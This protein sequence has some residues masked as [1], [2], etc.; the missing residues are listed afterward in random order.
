MDKREE[1]VI[2]TIKQLSSASQKVAED[3]M[4]VALPGPEPDPG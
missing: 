1:G 3:E 2:N 4:S